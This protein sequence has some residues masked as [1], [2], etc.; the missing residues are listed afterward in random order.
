MDLNNVRKRIINQIVFIALFLIISLI[1]VSAVNALDKA[2]S[3]PGGKPH[4]EIM[5][6]KSPGYP[7]EPQLNFFKMEIYPSQESIQVVYNIENTSDKVTDIQDS[8]D[9]A[10]VA[11]DAN[12][13]GDP[14]ST[15]WRW[16]Q[17]RKDQKLNTINMSPGEFFNKEISIDRK[18]SIV[19]SLYYIS[20][21]YN[22]ELVSQ[23]KIIEGLYDK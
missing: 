6:W 1:V 4:T 21:Y 11:G 12:K 7:K 19:N 20:A 10:L 5:L 23:Y 9:I 3:H 14:G 18:K 22:G 16:S 13:I 2:L 15:V 17:V 8:I